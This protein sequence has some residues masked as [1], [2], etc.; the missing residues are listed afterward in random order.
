LVVQTNYST[1]MSA[2]AEYSILFMYFF[3]E[4]FNDFMHLLGCET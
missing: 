1:R 3:K 2:G 4:R